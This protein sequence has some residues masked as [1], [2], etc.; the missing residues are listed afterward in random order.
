MYKH[1]ENI[2]ALKADEELLVIKTAEAAGAWE[3]EL[4]KDKRALQLE[5]R[6]QVSDLLPNNRVMMAHPQ[7]ASARHTCDAGGCA[8]G[9]AARGAAGAREAGGQAAAGGAGG[10]A[11]AGRQV[12]A[13]HAR[14]GRG[15]RGTAAGRGAGHAGG[16]QRARAGRADRALSEPVQAH[17][18]WPPIVSHTQELLSTHERELADIKAYYNAAVADNLAQ[19]KAL[20]EEAAEAR[21]ARAAADRAAADVSAQNRQLVEPLAQVCGVVNWHRD[22]LG[23]S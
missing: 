5:L 18:A 19:M 11:R 17:H 16:Q 1:Q 15:G 21:R 13:A 22:M 23:V 10:G 7:L 4:L 12:R 9:D 8:W 20:K 14:G 3:Q 6:E 2:A